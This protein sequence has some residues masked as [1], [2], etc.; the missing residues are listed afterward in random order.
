MSLVPYLD[1]VIWLAKK[2]W[3]TKIPVL[4]LPPPR[5]ILLVEDNLQDIELIVRYF[6]ECG[7]TLLVAKNAEAAKVW[8]E[9]NN[10]GLILLDMNLPG[11]K[12]WEL[13]EIIWESAPHLHVVVVCTLIEDVLNIRHPEFFSIRL[14]PLSVEKVQKIL[15]TIK[16]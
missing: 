12:G 1:A 15:D 11:Q 10:L 16:I 14:K 9:R 8:I 4:I 6:R 3:P 13:M 5:R 2:C 7:Q